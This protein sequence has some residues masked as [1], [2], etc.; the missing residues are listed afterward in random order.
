MK[1][2]YNEA[3]R[4]TSW[5]STSGKNCTRGYDSLNRLT[6]NRCGR[7][8]E[9]GIKYFYSMPLNKPTSV[10]LPLGSVYTYDYDEYGG[11]AG[12]RLPKS[13]STYKFKSQVHFGGK[14][15]YYH[16]LPGL[17]EPYVY[18]QSS[19]GLLLEIRP[20]T[21]N[22]VSLFKYDVNYQ[23]VET[24]SADVQIYYKRR[25]GILHRIEM[26]YTGEESSNSGFASATFR[27]DKSSL[28][29]HIGGKN[30]TETWE[31]GVEIV[32]DKIPQDRN[33][34]EFI[35]THLNLNETLVTDGVAYYSRADNFLI[36]EIHGREYFR[37]SY[38]FDDSNQLSSV[39]I[40]NYNRRSKETVQNYQYDSEGRLLRN[41]DLEWQYDGDLGNLI[42]TSSRS[43]WKKKKVKHFRYKPGT[44][45]RSDLE[46]DDSGRV[47]FNGRIKFTYNIIAGNDCIKRAVLND[48]IIEYF[49]DQ[50]GR[51]IGRKVNDKV[52]QFFYAYPDFTNLG[53]IKDYDTGL[54]HLQDDKSGN[55][56]LYDPKSSSYYT[57]RWKSVIEYPYE[58]ISLNLYSYNRYNPLRKESHS[59]G[60][61]FSN[62]KDTLRNSED[63]LSK[64]T[65]L[66]NGLFFANGPLFSPTSAETE[67]QKRMNQIFALS[68]FENQLPSGNDVRISRTDSALGRFV[69]FDPSSSQ[70]YSVS[71]GTLN[72][73]QRSVFTQVLE[74]AKLVEFKTVPRDDDMLFFTKPKIRPDDITALRRLG[75]SVNLTIH[76]SQTSEKEIKFL[77]VKVHLA[78]TILNI[79]YGTSPESEK[80]RLLRH[81]YKTISRKIWLK[82]R[83]SGRWS[84]RDMQSLLSQGFVSGFITQ[85]RLKN[86]EKYPELSTD[87]NNIEIVHESVKMLQK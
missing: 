76:E 75:P 32:W 30:I 14:I 50:N 47:I 10:E 19:S 56:R 40:T 12:I 51:L 54:V 66:A 13:D 81:A 37:A 7:I 29:G 67:F 69:A 34:G 43:K 59:R 87:L 80:A 25:S 31:N 52:T 41:N 23:I 28:S 3:F 84:P 45:M 68:Y 42:K 36:L 1:I 9:L 35:V 48:I 33:P 65:L 4:P 74:G 83:T 20:P 27:Y 21:G 63:M 55:C 53:G 18:Y 49:Y 85:Y 39:E 5:S 64:E 58:P 26:H 79:R 72:Q 70:V 82:E 6:E 11:L 61:I 77:D 78:D 73:V 16:Y 71:D 22:G 2:V 62:L 60:D 17:Q 86:I 15:K 8:R 44:Y 46:Y 38:K 57:P 24:I